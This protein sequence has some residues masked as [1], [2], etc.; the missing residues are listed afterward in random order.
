MKIEYKTKN[1]NH[2]IV[3]SKKVNGIIKQFKEKSMKII[4]QNTFIHENKSSID[5]N[6]VRT[7]TLVIRQDGI[8]GDFKMSQ[9]NYSE[10]ELYQLRN[11]IDDL[12]NNK[13]FN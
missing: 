1:N 2:S 6:E 5:N 12:L 4:Q 13:G 8:N 10:Q 3:L 7:F 11:S 9:M